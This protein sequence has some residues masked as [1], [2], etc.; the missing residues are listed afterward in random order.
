MNSQKII[1]SIVGI[2]VLAGGYF[3]LRTPSVDT[4][5]DI[6]IPEDSMSESATGAD[7]PQ[8]T[9]AEDGVIQMR[10]G[11]FFFSPDAISAKVG[12]EVQIDITSSGLHTFT[13]DELGVDVPTQDGVTT[14]VTFTPDKA[15]TYTYYCALPG[16]REG[17]QIGTLTVTQ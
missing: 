1:Y 2:V 14:R 4:D 9:V 10:S 6:L 15:G 13:I 11:S 7:I 12:Q 3:L 5:I 8:A 17:G 16:H